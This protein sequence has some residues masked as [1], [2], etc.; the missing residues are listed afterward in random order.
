MLSTTLLSHFNSLRRRVVT[1]GA[2]PPSP[3]TQNVLIT[4]PSGS[5]KTHIITTYLTKISPYLPFHA[6][7]V[8][9]F[10]GTGYVGGD[11]VDMVRGLYGKCDRPGSVRVRD[12]VGLA[13]ASASPTDSELERVVLDRCEREGVEPPES[14]RA[15]LDGEVQRNAALDAGRGVVYVDEIDKISSYSPH[16]LQKGVVGTRDVQQNLLKIVEEGEVEIKPRQGQASNSF[17]DR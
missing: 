7:D 6:C 1:S 3:P 2:G 10:S 14:M 11:V 9:S 13:A 16:G 8:T 15:F 5:R 4:G 12:V 17:M